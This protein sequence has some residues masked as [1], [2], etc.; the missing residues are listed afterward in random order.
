MSQ[1]LITE[2]LRA[3]TRL[4]L[5]PI[6]VEDVDA[7]FA[8]FSDYRVVRHRRHGLLNREQVRDLVGRAV[9]GSEKAGSGLAPKDATLAIVHARSGRTVGCGTLVGSRAQ[10]SACEADV[11]IHPDWWGLGLGAEALSGLAWIAF[12]LRALDEV[13]AIRLP[14]DVAGH[15]ALVHAGFERA[16]TTVRTASGGVRMEM[17]HYLMDRAAWEQIG[18][19]R[20]GPCTAQ[21]SRGR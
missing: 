11:A 19:G 14:R 12:E 9:Q 7:L 15:R 6:R 16:G 21:R 18:G 5:R 17:P 13:R 4:V 8:L 10:E 20:S 2:A 1:D 3:T